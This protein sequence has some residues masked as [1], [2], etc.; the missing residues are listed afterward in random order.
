MFGV[1]SMGMLQGGPLPVISGV[2]S[3]RVSFTPVALLFSAIY[4]GPIITLLI[5]WYGDSTPPRYLKFIHPKSWYSKPTPPKK[6]KPTKKTSHR[7]NKKNIQISMMLKSVRS[8]C[9][10][11]QVF[12][13]DLFVLVLPQM[14]LKVAVVCGFH[15]VV[16]RKQFPALKMCFFSL[17]PEDQWHRKNLLESLKIILTETKI[18]PEN[19][20]LEDDRFL[21]GGHIF[22]VLVSFRECMI[23]WM[24]F[25]YP[26]RIFLD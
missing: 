4:R 24:Q 11:F 12:S 14:T 26:K 23:F 17:R 16:M 3:P 10:Y 15:W 1:C 18:A 21:L 5:N 20:W 25:I 2:V 13:F 19:G 7:K 6:T 9:R 8:G 22:R